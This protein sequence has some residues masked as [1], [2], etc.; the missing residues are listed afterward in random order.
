MRFEIDGRLAGEAELGRLAAEFCASGVPLRL[1]PA[2]DDVGPTRFCN[3][4]Y[5]S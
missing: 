2:E 5:S 4:R 1:F 3:A